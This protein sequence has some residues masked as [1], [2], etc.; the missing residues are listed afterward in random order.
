LYFILNLIKFIILSFIALV[1][2]KHAQRYFA[3]KAGASTTLDIWKIRRIGFKPKQHLPFNLPLGIILP[4]LISFLSLGQI[5]FATPI[6]SKIKVKPAYRIGRKYI[7]LTEFEYAKI[8]VSAPMIHI[9][10]AL[11]LYPINLP[12][13]KDFVLI[14]TML[15]IFLML[16]LP[17]LLGT[18]VLFSSKPLYIFSTIFILTIAFFLK[19]TTITG[20]ILIALTLASL[21]LIAYFWRIYNK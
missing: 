4:I 19:L 12:I 18:T 13:I 9:L 10:I 3:N 21:G 5:Y 17:G 20:T 11:F 16:P 1:I 15:A 8:A 2:H 6:S 7:R 14:N